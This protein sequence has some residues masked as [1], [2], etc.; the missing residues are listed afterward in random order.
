MK[1]DPAALVERD[2]HALFFPH[3]LGHLVGL[4]VRDASGYLPGRVRSTRPGLN[5]LRTDLPLER[6][7][8]ITVEPGVYFIPALLDDPERRARYADCVAWDR[9]DALK[10]F[11]G[12]RIEDNVRI[13]DGE[14]ENLAAAIPK[15]LEFALLS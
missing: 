11:G 7:Y 1:G 5:M 9:I 3:G 10:S 12:I 14:P 6:D 13:T 8:V 4:G 2:L 15:S